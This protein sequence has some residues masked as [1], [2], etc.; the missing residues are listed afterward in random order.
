MRVCVNRL[1]KNTDKGIGLISKNTLNNLG[2]DKDTTYTLYVGQLFEIISVKCSDAQGDS[3]YLSQ[4]VFDKLLLVDNVDLDIWRKENELYLGPVIGI[5]VNLRYL[6]SI[7]DGDP[8]LSSE[9]NMQ[10]NTEENCLIYYFSIENI[11]WQQ[12]KIK[13]FTYIKRLGLWKNYWLPMPNV[14]YDRGTRFDTDE[15]LLVKDIRKK[16]KDDPNIY[17]I[18]SCD[19]LGKWKCY[20]CLSKYPE[21]NN[22]LPRTTLF[23]NFNDILIMLKQYEFVFLKFSYGSMGRQVLSIRQLGENYKINYYSDGLKEEIL[24]IEKLRQHVM[25]FATGKQYI[26]QQ[27]CNLIKYK[28]RNMDMRVL[29]NKDGNGN[30]RAMYNVCRVAAANSTITNYSSGGAEFNYDDIYKELTKDNP[31]INLPTYDEIAEVTIKIATYIEKEY[32]TFGEIGMDI[33]MDN[34]G[35]LWFIEGNT[36]PDKDPD[37]SVQDTEGIMLECVYILQYAK[38]LT[39]GRIEL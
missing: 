34:E 2:L 12:N 26:I 11:D 24:D 29:I 31:G 8:P 21:I 19:Y 6:K 3:L 35:K 30:W 1:Q 39:R 32:G 16:F 17:L 10:A 25:N 37:A 13:G 7:E 36:K 28:G 4:E 15:K 22:Y 5:F 23:S 27:G 9:K 38:Y 14:I 20:K 33:A 18:N